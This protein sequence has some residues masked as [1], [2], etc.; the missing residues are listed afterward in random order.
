MQESRPEIHLP[1]IN[2]DGASTQASFLQ[3]PGPVGF[4]RRDESLQTFDIEIGL[5]IF[6]AIEEGGYILLKLRMR[7][8]G[9]LFAFDESGLGLRA[10]TGE[11]NWGGEVV[12]AF[13]V[14]LCLLAH[15]L[16][17]ALVLIGEVVAVEAY[18]LFYIITGKQTGGDPCS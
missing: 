7:N 1:L 17:V 4:I 3:F 13:R 8:L 9:R 15:E 6:K 16:Q 18:F 12:G 10:E 11:G 5:D 14:F 2:A